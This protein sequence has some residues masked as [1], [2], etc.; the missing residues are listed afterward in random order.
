MSNLN[1]L[2]S[3]V[4]PSHNSALFISQTIESIIAQT[5]QDW[6]LLII[7]DCS[8]DNTVVIIEEFLNKDSRIK[9]F[10]TEMNS[11]SPV[12]PRNIG[13]KNA[14][15]RYI[16]FLDSDDIWLPTKLENQLK[17]F[18]GN[19]VS[20]VFSYYEK[21]SETGKRENRIVISPNSIAYH[22]L[23]KGNCI[24][25]LTAI[26]DTKKVGKYYF[27]HIEHEDFAYWLVILHCGFIAYNTNTVEALYRVRNDSLSKNK[28]KAS[29]W[30]WNIYRKI[31][32]IPMIQCVYYF[33]FYII[34]AVKKYT[35]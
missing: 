25:L 28:L 8:T 9:L 14:N 31:L 1:K 21:I 2:V 3:V 15:G 16:A 27:K 12:E 33:S 20:V 6:E 4:T 34:N 29:K 32:R 26:Y 5:Y 35:K 23:L 13:I 10:K 22:Q 17:L 7:D 18:E 19:D 30:T 24:G 11:K